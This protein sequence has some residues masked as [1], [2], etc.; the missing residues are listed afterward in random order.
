MP[1]LLNAMSRRSKVATVLIDHRRNLLL[2]GHITGDCQR[3]V[4][5]DLQVLRG[6]AD[7]VAADVGECDGGTGLGERLCGGQ[8]HS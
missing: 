5:L 7:G 6:G 8:S 4:S 3:L 1:A 2:V